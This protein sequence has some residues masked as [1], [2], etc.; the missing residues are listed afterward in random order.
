MAVL[1]A[2]ITLMRFIIRACAFALARVVASTNTDTFIILRIE[3][4]GVLFGD[5]TRSLY[6]GGL[7][8]LWPFDFSLRGYIS[9]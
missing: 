1:K 6:R 7:E 5:F 9:D 8:R 4:V 2:L 3:A